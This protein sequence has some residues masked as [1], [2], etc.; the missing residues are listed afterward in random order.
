[1]VTVEQVRD[2]LQAVYDPELGLNIIELGLV[3]DIQV[4]SKNDVYIVMT[5]TTPGCPLHGSITAGAESAIRSIEGVNNVDV[6]LVWQPAWS[7]DKMTDEA[8]KKLGM[9]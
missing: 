1:M 9:F 4:S 2:V 7:P 5:L 3:Y 6:N 8:K